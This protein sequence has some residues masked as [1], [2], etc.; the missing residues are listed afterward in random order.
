MF[1]H[2]YS[3]V[4]FLLFA[5]LSLV[6]LIQHNT[7]CISLGVNRFLDHHSRRTI[8][9]G[10]LDSNFYSYSNY[11][12]SRSDFASRLLIVANS[13]YP[14]CGSQIS[15]V[16]N[17]WKVFFC[18]TRYYTELFTICARQGTGV[19]VQANILYRLPNLLAKLPAKQAK[20]QASG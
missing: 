13:L 18:F 3:T 8:T 11:S 10:L 19:G 15:C 14:A 16:V 9:M 5:A 7:H 20:R 1:V 12:G 2:I 6:V 17:M 4:V